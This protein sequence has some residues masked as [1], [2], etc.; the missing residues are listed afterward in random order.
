MLFLENINYDS[1][2]LYSFLYFILMELCKENLFNIQFFTEP[3]AKNF[4]DIEN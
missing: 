3:I 4:T 2:F 1:L